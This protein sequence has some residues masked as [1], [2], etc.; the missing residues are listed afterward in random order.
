MAINVLNVDTMPFKGQKPGTSGLRKKVAEF[1]QP[2][3]MENFIQCTLLA[4]GNSLEGC[5]LVVGGDGRFGVPHAVNLIIQIAAANKVRKLIIGRDGILSTPAVSCVIRKKQA[6]GGIILTASHNPGGPQGDFGIKFNMDNGG[7]A[8]TD[9]TDRIYEFSESIATYTICKDLKCNFNEV[10]TNS[11]RIGDEERN[12]T[13]EVID[14]VDDY[15]EMMKNIFDFGMIRSYLKSYKALLNSLHGVTGP[16]VTRIFGDELGLSKDCFMKVNVLPDFGGGHPDPNLTYA[17][18]LVRRMEEE[19]NKFVL[20]AAFDGDGDRNMIL[21]TNAFFV[22][23][24]DSLAVIANNLDCIP[25][26]K[27]NPCPGYARSM[28]TSG[29][30]DRVAKAMSKDCFETPTGWKFFGNLLDAGRIAICGEESFG[31]GSNHIRE[32]D[33][34]WAA[35]AWLQI[36]AAKNCSVETILKEHWKVYGRNFFTRYDYEECPVGPCNKMMEN[37]QT[38]VDDRQSLGKEFFSN[39]GKKYV[40]SKT[41]NF[42]YTD[43]ID[44][45]VTQKQG[46]RIFFEDGSRIV[47]RLSGTGSSGATVRMYVDSYESEEENQLKDANVMLA[48]CIDVAIQISKL[49]HFTGRDKPTVIT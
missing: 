40:V 49:N 41:D 17:S 27:S 26:F 32:K 18:D 35:L 21:G 24:C 20:G 19:G 14:P 42:A 45:S 3:Y 44:S 31:T 2:H 15:L 43:P 38:F 9:F 48:P 46:I 7:P 30:L 1:T 4:L 12:F 34:I 10:G 13:V 5:T 22:T 29:A 16:Y 33:G 28:P 36:L 47:M 8:P 6:E 23:P 11:F 39:C 37:L 25:Y